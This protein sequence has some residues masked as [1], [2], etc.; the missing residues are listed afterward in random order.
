[1]LSVY[2][3]FTLR[4]NKVVFIY[5]SPVRWGVQIVGMIFQTRSNTI[6][7]KDT[8]HMSQSS[9]GNKF[10]VTTW[11]ESHGKALG[12]VIDGCP[13]GLPL[14]EEDIQKFLDRRKPGQSR[15]T[16]ARKEGDL[17]EILSGV[18]EG[19]TTGTPIS[20][21][22]RNTD[23]RSRD[24]GNIAYSYRP[25]HADY[26]FDQKYGFRDYRGGGRSSGR[27]TI[28]RVAAGA[29]ASKILEE[30][31]ISICT[32]TRS[33]GPV[34]IA[35]FNKEE[36]HQNAF[37]MPDAQAAVK[38]GEYLEECMKNQDSA[39]GVIE[40]RITGT[41]AGLGEPV[42]DK[43]SA[44]LAHALMSI[45]AVKAVEIG[46][47]I[48]VTSSNGSTDNDGFTVKDGEIIKTSN[49]AGGIMGGISDGS[50]IILRAHIKPT[51]SISQPQ[52]TV[53]KDKEPL[54]L[55]IHGRHDP[56]I[57]PRAVVVVE[58]MAAITLA[59]ALFVNMSSQMDKVRDFYRK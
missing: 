29:I 23:Q 42:F 6:T 10:K 40:C 5:K 1:M 4:Y 39:G 3:T 57:V 36:I 55:E 25:G 46:D 56:V 20:L 52:Q 2:K 24:Y 44:L 32:Y 16:T 48:A 22:V 31:G 21:M 53:T 51:P 18:F 47:G 11:G 34:E 43:L 14:C 54:S 45:G 13:A 7:G 30:L 9:F 27:E 49:H 26:T 50:E 35:S 8:N 37:Y 17:V 58:S 41:P 59:D 33:I 12:A 19:K 38:A 15:Y 28:G